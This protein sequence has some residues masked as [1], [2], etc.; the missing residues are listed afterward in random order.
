MQDNLF[1]F[2]P[3]ACA[4]E[5]RAHPIA[6]YQATTTCVQGFPLIMRSHPSTRLRLP[7]MFSV[8]R[9]N[10]LQNVSLRFTLR[11]AC[12]SDAC[13]KTTSKY[14]TTHCQSASNE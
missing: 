7:Q 13:I 12:Q 1:G 10:N 4:I 9:L 3:A 6:S 2:I 5:V 8:H 14:L 11:Q